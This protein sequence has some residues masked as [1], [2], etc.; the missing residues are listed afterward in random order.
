MASDPRD[1][2][3]VLR[4][5]L[6]LLEQGAYRAAGAGGRP[7]SIFRDSPT[8]LDFLESRRRSCRQCLLSDFIPVQFQNETIACHRIALDET[9]NTIGSLEREYNRVAVERAVFGWLRGIV[10]RLE[11][12]RRL[13]SAVCQ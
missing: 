7:L 3:E 2:L 5:E 13:E 10:A 8:C 1:A 4:F 6:Y 9:G 12:E 11:R